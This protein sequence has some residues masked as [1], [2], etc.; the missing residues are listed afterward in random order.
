M[1]FLCENDPL[2]QDALAATTVLAK[3]FTAIDLANVLK[4]KAPQ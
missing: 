4:P 2:H 3:P 1:R